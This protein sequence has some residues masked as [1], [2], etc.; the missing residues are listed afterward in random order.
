MGSLL[1]PGVRKRKGSAA[2]KGRSSA[3]PSQEECDD[4]GDDGEDQNEDVFKRIKSSCVSRSILVCSAS[5]TRAR[6]Q[7]RT[8]RTWCSIA[9]A[10]LA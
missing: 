9:I 8:R 5:L 7:C 10:R 6:A 1:I 4:D 2:K 3:P